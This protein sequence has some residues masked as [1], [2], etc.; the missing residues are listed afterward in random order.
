MPK[1]PRNAPCPCGSGHKFKKCCGKKLTE[2]QCKELKRLQDAFASLAD[3]KNIDE[4]RGE[5]DGKH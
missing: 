3:T 2:E 5:H 4:E 1:I